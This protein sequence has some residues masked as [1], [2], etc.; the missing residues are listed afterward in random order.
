MVLHKHLN[1]KGTIG[2]FQ[3][4][5]PYLIGINFILHFMNCENLTNNIS[6][7]IVTASSKL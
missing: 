2:N 1:K 7:V 6:N 3:S 4:C 5:W